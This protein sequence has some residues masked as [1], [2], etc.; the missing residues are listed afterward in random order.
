MIIT[1]ERYV[2]ATTEFPLEFED[3]YGN[4]VWDI[5]DAEKYASI[6]LANERLNN[7]DDHAK[8][9]FRLMKLVVS[10]EF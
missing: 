4:T 9:R 10:Y 5:K 7:Y 6:E 8:S 3:G 1:E 2:I